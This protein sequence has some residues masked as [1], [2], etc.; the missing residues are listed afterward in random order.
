MSLML[1]SHNK[2]LFECTLKR[3]H[4]IFVETFTKHNEQLKT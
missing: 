1:R 2:K 4:E 3:F